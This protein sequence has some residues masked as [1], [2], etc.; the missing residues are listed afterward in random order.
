MAKT[1]NGVGVL[2]GKIGGQSRGTDYSNP[3]VEEFPFMNRDIIPNATFPTIFVGGG[4]PWPGNHFGIANFGHQK[5]NPVPII[6]T[7]AVLKMN[8]YAHQAPF[9]FRGWARRWFNSLNV[10][11]K[12]I[13]FN[14][15]I[16]V[17]TKPPVF[18]TP[19][20]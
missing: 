6:E 14:G 4:N 19:S 7:P 20:G 12:Y 2:F 9:Q 8:H 16:P 18:R 10:Y 5:R 1:V 17:V 13:R 11:Q 15:E 3:H